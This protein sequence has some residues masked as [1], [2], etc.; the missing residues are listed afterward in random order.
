[1]LDFQMSQ[2]QSVVKNSSKVGLGDVDLMKCMS[3]TFDFST[4]DWHLLS[5]HGGWANERHIN[6]R[7]I[8][9]GMIHLSSN[10]GVS[11]HQ[12]NPFCVLSSGPPAEDHGH[13]YGFCLLYS[14]NWLME[15]E[16]SQTGCV[17]VNVGLGK[18][19]RIFQRLIGERPRQQGEVYH[20]YVLG[21]YRVFE[22][23]TSSFPHVLFESC[24]S[25]GGRFDA[26]LLAWC[27]QAWCSDNSD[28]FSRT[29]I[30]MGTSMWVLAIKRTG[31]T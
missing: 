28:A 24:A 11:S 6:T 14:G 1:M 10:R 17:R 5:L 12:M 29:R 25:G 23:I 19:T 30:Q 20:R 4:D 8:Q 21:L 16:Q 31:R 27:P 3:A 22:V 9:E 2:N 7:R 26:A 15:V 13:C 18:M